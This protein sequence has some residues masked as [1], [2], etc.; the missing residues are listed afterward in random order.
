MEPLGAPLLAHFERSGGSKVLSCIKY[1]LVVPIL[2]LGVFLVIG[3]PIAI[4][5]EKWGVPK[6][7]LP[8]F[9][10]GC[11]L[12]IM[13]G[14]GCISF[15]HF[16]RRVA[17]QVWIYDDRLEIQQGKERENTPYANVRGVRLDPEGDEPACVLLLED[18]RSIHIPTGIAP[19]AAVRTVLE[20]TL[21]AE[22]QRRLALEM[23]AG[24]DIVLSDGRCISLCRMMYSVLLLFVAPFL[25]LRSPTL[26]AGTFR[27]AM[28]GLRRARRGLRGGFSLVR[29]GIQFPGSFALPLKFDEVKPL[30]M[31]EDGIVLQS[32]KGGVASISSHAE[33]YWPTLS[34]FKGKFAPSGKSPRS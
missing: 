14:M 20:P 7:T 9:T 31:D 32:P 33:N 13:V 30:A 23:E 10:V 3:L 16:Q 15:R 28:T 6:A 4:F 19:F 1:A 21:I 2:S 29:E 25:M 12:L 5:L 24:R 27:F 34:W 22:L 18:G 17:A 26:S 11:L 8:W